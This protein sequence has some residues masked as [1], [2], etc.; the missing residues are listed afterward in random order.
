MEIY[1]F[2]LL[3]IVSIKN[4][5]KKNQIKKNNKKY[6]K[7]KLN[8]MFRNLTVLPFENKLVLFFFLDLTLYCNSCLNLEN[9]YIHLSLSVFVICIYL[10]FTS[11][12]KKNVVNCLL[13]LR[14]INSS[15]PSYNK[16][17]KEILQRKLK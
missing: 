3:E 15:L 16:E 13:D 7:E 10:K 9:L 11:K 1:V 2:I 8:K 17:M 5:T 6:L 4:A 14:A 12:R